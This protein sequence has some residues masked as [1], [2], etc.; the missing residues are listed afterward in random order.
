[1]IENIDPTLK[2][3]F[4]IIYCVLVFASL[5]VSILKSRGAK[6]SDELVA[7]VKTW[8]I[9]TVILTVVVFLGRT[10]SIIFF[11]LISFLALK[12]YF[13]L[14]ST[15]RAD[16][17]VLFW[18]YLSIPIQFYWVGIEWY[19]MFIIFIPVYIFLFLPLRMILIGDTDKFLSSLA[20]IH[21]GVMTAVFCIS[22]AAYLLVLDG[23][24]LANS[25]GATLLLFLV[26]LTEFNDIFQYLWGKF[27]GSRKVVPKVSPNKTV[28]GLIGGVGTTIFFAWIL[29]PYLTP[30]NTLQ[31]LAAGLIIGLG[32]FVGDVTISALKRDIGVK[33]SGLMLPGHGGVLDRVDS[34]F[35][36]SQ[37]FFHSIF[38]LFFPPLV[39]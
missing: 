4:A 30:L 35:Y 5:I 37:L 33:D 22:H 12:E 20:R 34:L 19:G 31:S 21:W 36:T 23:S 16:R 17:R 14:I 32:G 3:T 10:A 6:N 18:A 11:A 1:M 27:L 24:Y 15:R 38:Y 2:W 39:M 25:T 9:I 8:W 7:R 29:A 26:I 13:S 28:E